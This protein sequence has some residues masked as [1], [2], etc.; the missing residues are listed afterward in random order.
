M[1][2]FHGIK[3]VIAM[4]IIILCV[5]LRGL[6]MIICLW[7]N[8]WLHTI[9]VPLVSQPSMVM[10]SVSKCLISLT[11]ITSLGVT[12]SIKSTYSIWLIFEN[13]LFS[14]MKEKRK[15]HFK[16]F[17]FPLVS[18]YVLYISSCNRFFLKFQALVL[19]HRF[20]SVSLVLFFILWLSSSNGYLPSKLKV[21][22]ESHDKTIV[23]L[24]GALSHSPDLILFSSYTNLLFFSCL[25]VSGYILHFK[26]GTKGWCK[27]SQ[28]YIFC[29][30]G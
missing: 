7:L 4:Y 13:Q 8:H 2:W 28:F 14:F 9:L 19:I 5:F 10:R 3:L 26:R 30:M 6:T 21:R 20:F 18:S 15:I 22:L 29:R 12:K 27:P 16:T 25:G 17:F 23:L 24:F 11:I 1:L